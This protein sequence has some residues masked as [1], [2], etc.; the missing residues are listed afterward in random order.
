MRW[1]NTCTSMKQFTA[2]LGVL[3]LAEEEKQA[4]AVR[5]FAPAHLS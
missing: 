4:P 3:K 1:F 5:A 2:V